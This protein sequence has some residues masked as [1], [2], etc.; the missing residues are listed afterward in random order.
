MA[1]RGRRTTEP[2][3]GGRSIGTNFGIVTDIQ[4]APNGNLLVVAL[5]RGTVYEVF[6]RR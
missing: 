2:G 3:A 5:D 6:R 4:T 1:R